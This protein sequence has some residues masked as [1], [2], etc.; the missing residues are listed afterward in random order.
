[1]QSGTAALALALKAVLDQRNDDERRVL[2]P[3]YGC[4]DIVSAVVY[5]GGRPVL[6]DTA[7]SSPFM[8]TASLQ[9]AL[10]EGAAAVVAAHFL[11]IRQGLSEIRRLCRDAGATLVEDSAQRIPA[12]EPGDPLAD[13]VVLSFGRGKPATGLGG[14]ALLYRGDWR[15]AVDKVHRGSVQSARRPEGRWWANA[16]RA[17]FNTMLRP[18]AYG[19][20]SRIPALGIGETRYRILDAVSGLEPGRCQAAM[21]ALHG[22]NA[23][24]TPGQ[25]ALEAALGGAVRGWRCVSTSSDDIGRRLLRLPVLAPSEDARDAALGRLVDLGASCFYGRCLA[26]I[27][28]MPP[29]LEGDAPANARAF[30]S[31]LLTLPVHSGVSP[32]VADRIVA[33]LQVLAD[34]G[35]PA[36]ETPSGDMPGSSRS[37]SGVTKNTRV[38]NDHFA[39]P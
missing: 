10:S 31:R 23:V 21:A 20:A 28:G 33:E 29:G 25:A 3:A 15:E 13:L 24:P 11:G 38:D 9:Q 26:D 18:V 34:T 19:F 27:P 39:Q 36:P 6:V 4:P 2:V 16:R 30:A 8:G 22:W 12:W 7:P 14:G 37:G 5:A 35:A 17:M 1:M 32:A